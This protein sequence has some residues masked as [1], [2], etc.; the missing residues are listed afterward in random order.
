VK[1][2]HPN[3]AV[4][5]ITGQPEGYRANYSFVFSENVED[6]YMGKCHYANDRTKLYFRKKRLYKNQPG[7]LHAS[8]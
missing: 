2:K 6:W 5:I 8:G 3:K 4:K 7:G 1:L